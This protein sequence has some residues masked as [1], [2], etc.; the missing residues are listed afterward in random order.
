MSVQKEVCKSKTTKSVNN[1]SSSFH[2][3]ITATNYN[4]QACSYCKELKMGGWVLVRSFKDSVTSRFKI[5]LCITNCQQA[6]IV[7]K[8]REIVIIVNQKNDL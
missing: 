2:A 8:I 1:K 7:I 4:V 5:K 6:Q 3:A